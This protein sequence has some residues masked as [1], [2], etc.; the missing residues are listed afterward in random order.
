MNIFFGRAQRSEQSP[1]Y[2]NASPQTAGRGL[3]FRF[4]QT[5]L[6]SLLALDLFPGPGLIYPAG[7]D[8]TAIRR[9]MLPKRAPRQM[10][11]RLFSIR[12]GNASRR[13]KFPRL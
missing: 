3:P 2:A 6:R 10:A 12:F 8:S 1:D 5:P 4:C 9:T 13:H 11:L 7:S